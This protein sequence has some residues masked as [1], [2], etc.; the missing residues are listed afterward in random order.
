MRNPVGFNP[1]T[2][3]FTR[4]HTTSSINQT[5]ETLKIWASRS[6]TG[7]FGKTLPFRF[8]EVRGK[9]HSCP[10]SREAINSRDRPPL[11]IILTNLSTLD[12]H[13]DW[14]RPGRT[15]V[16]PSSE[17]AKDPISRDS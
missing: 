11:P 9:N 6:A 13:I 10:G 1:L 8:T 3:S 17:H 4:L 2:A 7:E 14:S 5:F 16:F 12:G 15:P